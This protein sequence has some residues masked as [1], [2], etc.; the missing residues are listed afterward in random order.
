MSTHTPFTSIHQLLPF[1][2]MSVLLSAELPAGCRLVASCVG[3]RGAPDAL[4]PHA[5]ILKKAG[6]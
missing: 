6:Y 2:H 3:T 4:G 5:A 1:G